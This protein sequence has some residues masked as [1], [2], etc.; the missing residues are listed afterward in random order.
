MLS[1]IIILPNPAQFKQVVAQSEHLWLKSFGN[2]VQS[3]ILA[4]QLSRLS[5][6]VSA[7]FNNPVAQLL[8]HVD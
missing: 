2:L 6:E 4:Q 3:P 5:Q 1:I 8:G 7:S